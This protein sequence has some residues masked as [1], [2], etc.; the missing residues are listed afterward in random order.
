M[1]RIQSVVEAIT[2]L[3]LSEQLDDRAVIFALVLES[4]LYCQAAGIDW[5]GVLSDVDGSWSDR[6]ESD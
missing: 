5:N 6:F 1:K 4:R 2:Q 3:V